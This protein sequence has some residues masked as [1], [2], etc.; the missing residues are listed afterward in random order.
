MMGNQ[1]HVP[2]T[3]IGGNVNSTG[4][5]S[6]EFKSNTSTSVKNASPVKNLKSSVTSK[7]MSKKSSARTSRSPRQRSGL[8]SKGSTKKLGVEDLLNE[9]PTNALNLV[10]DGDKS[11][12][13]E[14]KRSSVTSRNRLV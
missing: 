1:S 8:N 10:Q 6:I 2:V 12:T 5:K 11:S 4:W 13:F 7:A 14:A 3:K 9:L